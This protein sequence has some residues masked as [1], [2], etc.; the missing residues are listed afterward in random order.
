[1]TLLKTLLAPIK[2]GDD[3]TTHCISVLATVALIGGVI[4]ILVMLLNIL[5]PARFERAKIAVHN[6]KQLA[7]IQKVHGKKATRAVIY[8]ADKAYFIGKDRRKVFIK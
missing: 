7:Q 8:E 6:E 1:M 3:V 4:I 2:D 5:F